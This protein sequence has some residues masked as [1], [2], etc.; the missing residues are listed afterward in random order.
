MKV[1]VKV[2]HFTYCFFESIGTFLYN[3]L[4][5]HQKFKPVITAL[6]LKHLLH[7]PKSNIYKLGI[8]LPRPGMSFFLPYRLAMLLSLRKIILQTKPSVIHAHYGPWGCFILPLR[9]I[10]SIPLVVTFYGYDI[11]L[12]TRRK[13]WI[14]RYRKLF[15]LADLILAEG[16]FMKESL[17]RLGCPPP[18][19]AIQKIGIDFSKLNPN[20]QP[21]TPNI[22]FAGHFAPKKGIIDALK[23]INLLREELTDFTFTLIG[24]GPLLPQ[25]KEFISQNKMD[26]YTK[27]LGSLP[28]DEYIEELR[29][30]T[31]FLHPSHTAPDGETE[32]GAP[33]T[34]LEAQALNIPVVSTTHADIPN[35]TIPQKSALLSNEHDIEGL[36]N[37]LKFL[38]KNPEKAQEMG[39]LGRDYVFKNHRIELTMHELEEKYL[40]LYLYCHTEL[41]SASLS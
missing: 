16:P 36:C 30:A 34:I 9:K 17:I 11:S 37:S 7:S 14:K 28:Y 35:I 40:R 21:L 18:K 1:K 41:V 15:K 25:A 26:S 33:T 4:R 10:T 39:K 29:K 23:S 27:L 3:T 20:P 24:D 19:I 5:N 6:T 12:P 38:L 22:T 2:L 13:V 8:S 31:I 32:G